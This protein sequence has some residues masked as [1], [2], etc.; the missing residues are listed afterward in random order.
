[1]IGEEWSDSCVKGMWRKVENHCSRA[2]LTP[3]PTRPRAL[4][5]PG[6]LDVEILERRRLM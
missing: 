2:F 5:S 1:M 6:N 4:G 3:S